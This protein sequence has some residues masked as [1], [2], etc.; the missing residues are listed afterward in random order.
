MTLSLLRIYSYDV[1]CLIQIKVIRLEF[2]F[3]IFY[4][5]CCAYD[6]LDMVVTWQLGH[7]LCFA[8]F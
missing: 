8:Y 5:K 7:F 3:K 6:W 1:Y 2:D 4:N